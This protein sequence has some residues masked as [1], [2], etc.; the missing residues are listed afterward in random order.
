MLPLAVEA[1]AQKAT[2]M[3][4]VV[5]MDLE[6]FILADCDEGDNIEI[7]IEEIMCLKLSVRISS[8]STVTSRR[9]RRHV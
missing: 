5:A 8:V 3:E 1:M 9:L 6:D 4:V 2:A 7:P